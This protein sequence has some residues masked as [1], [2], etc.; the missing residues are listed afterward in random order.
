[1]NNN[2]YLRQF[3]PE[4][5]AQLLASWAMD[6]S[7]SNFFRG[8][9]IPPTIEDCYNYSKWANVA[10][11]MIIRQEKNDPETIGMMTLSNFDLRHRSAHYSAIATTEAEGNGYARPSV[12]AILDYCFKV[13]GM[14]K[15][16]TVVIEER[17]KAMYESMGFLFEGIQYQDCY[18][19]G[20]YHDSY[21]LCVFP[22]NYKG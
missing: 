13:L 14:R 18:L 15:M 19:D 9:V 6:V 21:R 22:D 8:H 11:Y 7:K 1:M 20:K 5:D 2:F 12:V 16:I 4:V 3:I 17:L 10:P